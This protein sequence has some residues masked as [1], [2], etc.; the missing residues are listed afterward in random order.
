MINIQETIKST[1]V[2]IPFFGPAP[3]YL[4]VALKSAEKFN[5]NVIL[6]GDDSNSKDWHNHFNINCLNKDKYNSFLRNY[7]HLSPNSIDFEI[8]CFKRYYFLEE[9]M[10]FSGVNNCVMLDSDILTYCN[11]SSE[12]KSIINNEILAALSTVELQENYFW[13]SSAHCSFFS[14]NGIEDFTNFCIDTYKNN[15]YLLKEKYS[16]YLKNKVLSGGVSDMTLLYL[17]SKNNPNIINLSKVFNNKTIDANINFSGNYYKIEYS[18]L[19]H[20]KYFKFINNLPFSYNKI[21]KS[22]IQ[23]LAIH[24]QGSAKLLMKDVFLKRGFNFCVYLKYV[25]IIL[26][27]CFYNTLG[28]FLG[29]HRIRSVL[30]ILKLKVIK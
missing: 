17:W 25:I 20:L 22:K 16:Y 14:L 24:F 8:N 27:N 9:W 13:A 7:I 19:F 18:S 5:E 6:L 11:Y 30:K 12:F 3:S 21:T 10:K 26:S 1:S 15:M 4:I 23:F 28:I 2:I 29:F